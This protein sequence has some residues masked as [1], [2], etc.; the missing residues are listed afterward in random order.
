MGFKHKIVILSSLGFGLGVIIGVMICAFSSTMTYA[1]GNLYLCSKELMEA[2]GNPLLAFT[3]QAFA[4]GL[5]GVLGMGGSAVYSI[6]EWGLLKCTVT[7]YIAVIVG[8]FILAFSMRWFTFRQIFAPDVIITVAC[9]TVAYIIIWMANYL[10]C[11]AQLK[12]IN[13]E[14]DELKAVELKGVSGI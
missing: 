4:S 3:I 5:Y 2:V 10:S 11:K 8:F 9:I 7:H 6:E 12:E 1:D 13:K 14:L